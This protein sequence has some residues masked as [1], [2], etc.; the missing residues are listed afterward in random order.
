MT[1]RDGTKINYHYSFIILF[2]LLF[3]CGT[4]MAE[5]AS[6]RPLVVALR[7]DLPP[8]SFLGDKGQPAGLF[9]DMW[10]LWSQKTGREIEFR[11]DTWQNS[12]EAFKKGQVDIL[13]LLSST[14]ER[15]KWI[16][17]SQPIYG[18]SLAF[19][20]L[21]DQATTLKSSDFKGRKVGAVAGTYPQEILQRNFPDIEGVP[22]A[23]AEEMIQATRNGTIRAFL[24][25]KTSSPVMFRKFGVAGEF[26]SSEQQYFPTT[27]HAGILKKNQELLALV[28]KGF[29]LLTNAELAEIEQRWVSDSKSRYYR[30]P[31]SFPSVEGQPAIP[32]RLSAAEESWLKKH[33]TVTITLPTVFPPLMFAENGTGVQGIVPDIL[34]IFSR[35]TGINFTMEKATLAELPGLL[36]NRRTDLFPAFMDIG[37]DPSIE[38]TEP[39]FSLSWE[40]VNRTGDPFILNLSDLAWKK[41]A[42][43]RDAPIL[44]RLQ[45]DY[46][47]FILRPADTPLAAL[48][49]VAAGEADAFIGALVVAGH[50]IQKYQLAGLK[51]A[52]DGGYADFPFTFA[53]RSDWPELVSILNKTIRAIPPE[54]KAKIFAKWMP[55][56][57]EQAVSWQTAA[58][59]F[60]LLG[61]GLGTILAL[62]LSWNRKMAWEIQRRKK[63]EI[64]LL[65]N[66]QKFRLVFENC[67]DAIFWADVQTGLLTRCN[68][69]AEELLE[70][71][72]EEL[73]G[74]H[75]SQL[76]PPDANGIDEFQKSCSAQIC[77]DIE[78]EVLSRTG[79][80]IP[81]RISTT[82]VN[83]GS[84]RIIQGV[85]HDITEQRR[86]DTALRESIESLEFVLRG[87]RLGYWDWNITTNE[88]RRNERCAEMLGYSL[89]EIANTV[90]QWLDLI[91]PDD[92][93]MADQ[94]IQDHLEGWKPIYKVEYR[95]LTKDGRIRWILD[96]AQVVQRDA[97]GRPSRMSGTHA[98]ITERKRMEALQIFLAQTSKSL[99]DETFFEVL[100]R[101][102]AESLEMDFICID[103]LEGD[104]LAARTVAVWSD[105]KFEDNVTYALKDTP[106]GEVVGKQVC[107]YP[108]GVCQLFP[109]DQVLQDLQAESYVGVTLFNHRGQPN[110]LIAVISRKPLADRDFTENVLKKVAVRAGSELER[111]QAEDALQN[112]LAEKEMLLKEVH[113]RVKNNLAAIMGLVDMQGQTLKDEGAKASLAELSVRIKSMALV[114]EQ[115]YHSDNIARI[116]FQEYLQALTSHL[117]F[118]YN[119]TENVRVNVAVADVTMGLDSAVPCGLL[120]TELVT[121]SFKYAFPEGKARLGATNCEINVAAEWDGTGYTL[122]VADN[123]VGLPAGL[124]WTKTE[125][126]GLLLVE[127]L[128][129]H[130]LQGKM[131]VDC[132]AGTMF[133]LRFTPKGNDAL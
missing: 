59:W 70:R 76:H 10:N 75:Q 2:L 125:T 73:I 129:Q 20:F 121:N 30:L 81:V 45:N 94:A 29:D 89:E 72:R 61:G 40:I 110:G 133:R 117:Q 132:T 21:K 27:L 9:V 77:A 66:E 63:A 83:I 127:M 78:A 52:G 13:G 126:L 79:R 6:P 67:Q 31:T 36:Q 119:P 91:H 37:S 71:P 35:N 98:D 85:F 4:A 104:G 99:E 7:N 53:V 15:Q 58:Q 118:S 5:P 128:G 18:Y 114:H 44:N 43:V 28:D 123:G 65:D 26:Q 101:Y 41:V 103:R 12:F 48:Q 108:A 111:Q 11:L 57:Y 107:C 8:I 33:K 113:H 50:V 95:M 106:C 62:T 90:N 16:A 25:N 122:T 47:Q 23:T 86:M 22:F 19:Y 32:L 3:A 55:V 17:F 46:P 54:E 115:L 69:K 96:Q 109:R 68:A 64:D 82:I 130:Q 131:E 56:R 97:H 88:V 102:L 100:A 87:S 38:R 112:S 93:A 49:S 60:L 120:V 51:I 124:D 42:V 34:E 39:C 84:E 105:G 74:M 1:S 24:G 92:R 80:R 116:D 14:P